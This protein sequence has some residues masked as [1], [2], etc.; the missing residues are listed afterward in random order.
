[1]VHLEATWSK[2]MSFTFFSDL[3][4]EQEEAVLFIFKLV[5]NAISQ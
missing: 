1:M 3:I 2:V 5:L 4:F